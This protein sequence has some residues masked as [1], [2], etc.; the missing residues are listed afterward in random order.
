[1]KKLRW[2]L[3]IICLTGL[4]VGI[5]LLGEQP[6]SL[7]SQAPQPVKGGIYA[8][9]MVGSF[10]RLNPVLDFN[11]Q[12]DRD[13]DRLIFSGLLSFDERGVAQPDLADLPG[14][15]QDGKIYNVTINKD[16]RWHDGQPVTADDVIFTI[17]LM[18]NGGSIV[19]ADLQ[20]FWNG[21]QVKSFSDKA[22]QFQLPEA[23]APFEDYLTFGVLPKHLLESQTIDQIVKSSFNLQPVG[24]G[25]FRFDHLLVDGG[26]I[27]GVAL[28]AYP[29]YY[30]KKPFIQQV[31]LHYY[32]DAASAMKAYQDGTVLG[33]SQVTPDILNT[34]L[35]EP[36]LSLYTVRRPE[37]SLI[38]FN[39][40]N[41]EM[42]FFQ[43]AT[44]RHALLEGINRQRLINKVLGSQAII[45]DGPI[46]PGTW[47]YNENISR[48]NYNVDDAQNILKTAGY[49]VSGDQ[50]TV[51]KKGDSALSFTM[52]YPDDDTHKAVALAI[53]ADWAVLGVEVKLQAMPYDQLV[54]ENLKQ[55]TYQAA[56]I[57]LNL[58][59]SPDPDPYP[60]WDQA[61]ATGGQNYS[62]W[63]NRMASEYL[64]QARVTTDMTERNRLYRNFQVIFNNELPALPL[65]YPVYTYGVDKAVQGVS[66]GP[67]F[68]SSDRF[69][70][71]L[72]WYLAAKKTTTGTVTPTVGK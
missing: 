64:E 35:A 15:S 11:N 10:Q 30:G 57:D 67:L 13:A 7:T 53:Q 56:L 71:I 69:A 12:A 40:N 4:V 29:D 20:A 41:P 60:F 46:F 39:L 25:P 31:I 3:I 17:D 2:Q 38:L 22:L 49:V 19:P 63:D 27:T 48:V 34:A 68:D 5:L 58:A 54:N 50:Q 6:N 65:Y 9:A 23:F 36:N 72:D 42:P 45:A 44:I 24:S 8:E 59:R 18:R 66:V 26:Q 14:I 70:T 52:L 21:I 28:T 16:A 61:Q 1:M 62:Q 55:L 33:I 43:D 37:L 32:G 47:A 51:R